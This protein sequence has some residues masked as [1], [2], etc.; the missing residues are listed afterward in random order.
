VNPRVS[1][2]LTGAG[3]AIGAAV[4]S[5]G[6]F[7]A[8]LAPSWPRTAWGWLL[9]AALGLPLLILAEVIFTLCF[10]VGPP[11][12]R[13]YRLADRLFEVPAGTPAARIVLLLVR[14]VAGIALCALVLW[15]L[16]LLLHIGVVR[17]QFR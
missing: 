16:H 2:I 14:I 17:A 10:A 3:F 13:R 9:S 12:Y 7:V 5:A 11:R 15:L 6:V 8:F 1:S 4:L